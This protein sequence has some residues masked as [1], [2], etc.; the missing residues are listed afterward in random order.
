MLGATTVISILIFVSQNIEFTLLN[1]KGQ[2]AEAQYDLMIFNIIIMAIVAIPALILF[3]WF[4][5]K[6]R[7]TSDKAV[8]SP[9]IRHSKFFVFKMWAIPSITV[10][11]LIIAMWPATHRLA[12][13][14]PLES[15]TETL[16]IQVVALRWKWLFI[17]PE[18]RIASLNFVQ[19]P[20]DTPVN[21]VLTADETPMSSF[22][23]PHI[24]GQLYAMTGH[25]N[26]I[27][28]MAEEIGEYTGRSAEI[29][30]AG[31]AGMTFTAKASSQ[32]DFDKWVEEVRNG[33]EMLDSDMYEKLLEPSESDKVALFSTTDYDVYNN[34]LDKYNSASDDHGHENEHTGEEH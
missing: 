15:A 29:N 11:V 24:G 26:G 27:N 23:I 10:A 5:W 34:V 22:W 6:F 28:L 8:Y 31:F 21:F 3:Y 4:A 16:N 32:Q 13:N 7:D 2:V 30:G 14:K 19:I 17:Y 18:Q 12:P 9:N 1:P 20:E 25:R 33:S